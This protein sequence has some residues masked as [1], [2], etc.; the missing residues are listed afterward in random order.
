MDEQAEQDGVER[1]PDC[2]IQEGFD[3]RV[4]LVEFW[5]N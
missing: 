5:L 3:G 1:G 4:E 2:L